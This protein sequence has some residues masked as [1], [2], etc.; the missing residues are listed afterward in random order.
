[1]KTAVICLGAA[2]AAQAFATFWVARNGGFG[3]G[4]LDAYAYGM[5]CSPPTCTR[6]R[7]CCEL[8][9][10][11]SALADGFWL[12][13]SSEASQGLSGRGSSQ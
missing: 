9:C 7:P 12:G 5:C 13:C 4:D 11:L 1:M 6:S 3:E 8:D 10:R 2:G